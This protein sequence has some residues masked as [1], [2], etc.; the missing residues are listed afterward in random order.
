M[1]IEQFIDKQFPHQYLFIDE[2]N[3]VPDWDKSIKFMAD[4]GLFEKVSV[5]LT[6]SDSQILKTAV[7]RLPGRRGTA[8]T[9]DYTYHPLSYKEFVYLKMK[10][11]HPI[12]DEISHTPL[13]NK[14]SRYS[15]FH[16]KLTALLYEYLIHG[17]YLPA[18]TDYEQNKNISKYIINT[19]VQWIVGDILKY[20]KNEHY[21]WEI[22]RGVKKV[23]QNS[24]SWNTLGKYLSIEHHKT[25]ADYCYLL[26][27]MHVL[28]IQEALIEHKL[29]GGPK[30][31][32]KIYFRDPFIDH[33]VSITINADITINKIQEN[34]KNNQ[35]ASSYI[36]AIAVDHCKRMFPTFYIK[37]NKG[38]VDIAIIY[39]NK[40]IP[41]EVK[42]SSFIRSDEI[43]Q[44][45]QYKNGIILTANSDQKIIGNS[46]VVPLVRFLL[47]IDKLKE[48]KV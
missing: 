32:R 12:L 19:Y 48:S 47:H 39:K 40:F 41:I 6:G 23:Y 33:A 38:E 1:L 3:Y 21:L 16:G 2:V 31:N 13:F 24:I 26:E 22:F 45:Q 42:W 27:S 8:E 25:V 5:I 34:L 36:E 30:K 35:F 37:G 4:T 18:I 15:K 9:V 20:N 43:K 46:N 14:I 11:L 44:I 10:N 17:G 7:K 28:N 29:T